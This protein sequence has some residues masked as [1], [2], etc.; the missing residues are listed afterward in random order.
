M[1][2]SLIW[3][4][5]QADVD[6]VTYLRQVLKAGTATAT[7]R[8]EYNGTPKGT[9]T[10]SDLNRVNTA[11]NTVAAALTSAGYPYDPQAK[12]NWAKN[13]VFLAS[14]MATYIAG[15]QGLRDVFAVLPTTPDTPADVAD[16]QQANDLEKIVED[17]Y[18]LYNNM[19]DSQFYLG[20]LYLGEV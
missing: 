13:S 4:R 2:L 17:V 9:Y 15:V 6:R 16:F 8:T 20:D 1:A 7:E 19:I 3:D 18:Q 10:A 14:D 12:T 5:T 11:V